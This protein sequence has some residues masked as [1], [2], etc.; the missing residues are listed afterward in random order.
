MELAAISVFTANNPGVLPD[1]I[2]KAHLAADDL[3]LEAQTITLS[4]DEISEFVRSR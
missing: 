1:L 3:A 2:V 4:W